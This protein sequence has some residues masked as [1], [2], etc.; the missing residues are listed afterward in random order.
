MLGTHP[1][2]SAYERCG[3]SRLSFYLFWISP[4]PSESL[5]YWG[6]GGGTPREA[7][8]RKPVLNDYLDSVHQERDGFEEA[9]I[10]TGRVREKVGVCDPPYWPG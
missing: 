1:V 2:T 9:P 8:K 10:G 6:D 7:G 3:A 5:R 4:H